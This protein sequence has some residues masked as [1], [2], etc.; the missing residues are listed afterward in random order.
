MKV[1]KELK[2]GLIAIIS[3]TILIWGYNYMKKKNL[4]DDSRVYYSEFDNVQGL[5]PA[6]FV[7]IN[8]FQVGNVTSI[9][10]NPKKK[11]YFIVSYTLTNDFA[12]SE[13]S[14]TKIIPPTISGMGS[15]ELIIIPNYDGEQAKSGTYLKGSI[16]KGLISSFGDKLDPLN[17]NINSTLTN[18]DQLVTNFNNILD[19]NTQNNLKAAISNLTK[20][21]ANFNNVSKSLDQILLEN[22]STINNALTNVNTTFKNLDSISTQF[23][24]AN[25]FS[26]F[27]TTINNLDN[28]LLNFDKILTKVEKGDGTIA[29]L[30]NDK[31]LYDNLENASKELEE[32]LREVKEHPKR[33]V[34]I[35]VFG[36]KDKRGYVRDTTK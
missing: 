7:T 36:K 8:G 29:K 20:T 16:Q 17:V 4:F 24:N 18:L 25:L 19:S 14:E 30:I 22:K 13:N 1:S 32:L 2:T 12:F 9:K 3:I 6:S 23:K 34:H 33:F 11:G 28:L 35:S 15:A 27:K 31:G 26:N 21:L 5:T 10:F